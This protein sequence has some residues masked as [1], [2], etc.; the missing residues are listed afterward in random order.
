MNSKEVVLLRN[1]II[2]LK[3]QTDLLQKKTD[4]LKQLEIAYGKIEAEFEQVLIQREKQENLEKAALTK[5][6]Q[7]IHRLCQENTILQS[8]NARIHQF[9]ISSDEQKQHG[10]RGSN[11]AGNIEQENSDAEK[12]VI[13]L[14]MILSEILPK[15]KELVSIQE[16]LKIECEAQSTTLEEQR[17][18]I[19]M[20]EKALANAQERIAAKDR[21]AIDAVAIVDKCS[22]LQKLLQE[23]LDDKQKRQEE[24]NKQ[25]SQLEM[26]LAQMR[27]QMAKV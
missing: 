23:A 7:Q 24:H 21:Q 9:L 10:R 22:H 11:A 12:Q 6:E 3:K 15:N 2:Y 26:E 4:R 27:M 25:K 18:H 19:E 8:E 16:R 13:Q 5:M 1:E 20:L 17:T 14:N